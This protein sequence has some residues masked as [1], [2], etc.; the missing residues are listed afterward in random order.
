MWSID[1]RLYRKRPHEP[2]AETVGLTSAASTIPAETATPVCFVWLCRGFQGAC[3]NSGA[4]IF[5]VSL[6]SA[7]TAA[8]RLGYASTCTPIADTVFPMNGLPIRCCCLFFFLATR[9]TSIP[10]AIFSMPSKFRINWNMKA[11]SYHPRQFTK[12]RKRSEP[13]K[14]FFIIR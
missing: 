2:S 12:F 14:V 8:L 5:G 1:S 3:S 4:A 13:F 7:A 6:G 9:I 11:L 10:P